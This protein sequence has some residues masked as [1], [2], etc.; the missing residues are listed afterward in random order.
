M[1]T[2]LKPCP[3]CGK[4]TAREDVEHAPD[5]FFAVSAH[6]DIDVKLCREAWNRRT[7]PVSAPL[8]TQALPPPEII[9]QAFEHI[10]WLT[11]FAYENGCHELGYDPVDTVRQAIAHLER[12]L[13]ERKPASIDTPELTALMFKWLLAGNGKPSDE[14]Y[15][16][17][18]AYIDGHTAGTAPSKLYTCIDKGGEYE[19]IGVA[20]GAG[21]MRGNFV[22]IYRDKANGNLFYRT[23]MDFD[24][25]MKRIAAAP[26][27]MSKGKEK[28]N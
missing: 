20:A 14:A 12:E 4:E 11:D 10:K 7:A 28:A 22:H 5:C 1:S 17:I 13:A 15:R 19:H 3:F 6:H 27:S 18:I 25:R 21:V 2:E 8:D 23:P 24:A 26:S 9:E 16:A